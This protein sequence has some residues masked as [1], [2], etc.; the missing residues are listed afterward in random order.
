MA[1]ISNTLSYPGQSPIEGADY[2][3]GTAANSTP[4]GLQTKTFT[5]QGIANFII[6]TAFNGVSYRLPIFTASS[7][8]QESVLLVNS[9]FYQDTAAQAGDKVESVLGTTVYLDNGSGVGSLEVAQNV[10]VKANLTVNNNANILNDFYVAGDSVFDDSVTMN[11][12]IRLIGDVYDSTNTQ[13]NQEQVLVSDGNGKVTW[14]NFQGSGLEYQSAWDALTNVPNLQIYPLTADNTGKYWVVSVPGTTGLTNASGSLI[15]DWEPGDWA[16]ISEDIAGNVFWDKIDNSSVLTGQGTT[17]NIA[18]W[19]APRELGDAP[20]KLGAGATSLIFNTSSQA[21]GDNSNAFGSASTAQGQVSF[22]AGNNAAATGN[23]SV[24]IGQNVISSGLISTAMGNGSDSTGT[25]SVA[26]GNRTLSS[27]AGA[28][29]LGEDTTA[30]GAASLASNKLTVA[31]GDYSVAFGDS[32][33]AL[34]QHSFAGGKD[35]IAS[36]QASFAFGENSFAQG[37]ASTSI[38]SGVTAKGNRSIALG[39]DSIAEQ[40]GSI[41][42]GSSNVA[43]SAGNAGGVA[44]GDGNNA[45]G[46]SSVAIGEANN[47]AS[48][49]N[50][51]V[52]MGAASIVSGEFSFAVGKGNT[53]ESTSGT[54]IGRDNVVKA[55]ATNGIALG[56]ENQVEKEGA[57]AIGT[58]NDALG[59][60]S[61]AFGYKNGSTADYSVGIGQENQATGINGT[62]I[63]KS[64]TASSAAAVALGLTTTASGSASVALN[65]STVASGGDSFASGFESTAT[66]AAGTAMGY[67]TSALGDYAFAAGYLSNTNGDSAIAMGDNAKADAANTVAI[68][69][70]IVV[71]LKRS[72]GIG[73]NLL[74]KGDSQVV[75]GNGLE[76]TSFKE[77]VLGSFNLPPSSPS[78]NTWVGTDDLFTIGNGQ[79]INTKSNALVLNKNGELKLPSYGGGTIT[80]TA[81]YNLGVD[82]SGNV[83]EVSTGGGGGGTVTGSG[84]QDYITKWNSNTAVGNSIMFE[85]GSGIGLGTVTPSYAFDN[86]YNLGRYASFGVAFAEVVVANN[87]INI[88]DVDGNG[89][90]LGLYDDFSARAVLVKGGSVRI[91]TGGAASERLEVEG[92][93]R[94]SGSGSQDDIYTTNDR[95]LLSSGGSNGTSFLFDDAA[96]IITTDINADVGVGVAS[97]KAKLDV[98]GAIKIADTSASPTANTV[99]SIRYRVSG[100]NSY[101]DM[102]MQDGATSYSWVNIVQKNW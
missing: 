39:K 1:K 102:V 51:A 86:H 4:I 79:D 33:E 61:I 83:I 13:G 11:Q 20:I 7:A 32:S 101:I 25:A 67:R 19:T 91:G 73:S 18:I 46:A 30:S 72:V 90:A 84:T 48:T 38:G 68:G 96:G 29:A 53:V 60:W 47:V 98:A 34:G 94:L 16:I 69:A 76:G 22:A 82:A 12:E 8:G 71:D 43:G 63:G 92:N 21:I 54:G 40:G 70:D 6:D 31:S 44:I 85:G 3:I 36:Q 57:V 41:A 17:G 100:N 75:I 52:V 58:D 77:T 99:G 10:L 35:S 26:I 95:L 66:G 74:V 65:N 49:A 64:N 42:I 93:I 59:K 97:P 2:L 27:G 45:L 37:Q 56:Y 50:N 5:I 14:Q 62:A 81:T 88:G 9:L 80:G 24:A 78:V 23:Y 55:P 28:T 87:V 15:T 89:A